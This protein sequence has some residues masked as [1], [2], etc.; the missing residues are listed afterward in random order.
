MT[1]KQETF[2][3]AIVDGLDQTAAYRLAYDAEESSQSTVYT[4]SAQLAA[5]TKVA[6]RIAELRAPVASAL[7]AKRIHTTETLVDYYEAIYAGAMADHQWAP[8]NKATE[9]IA[10]LTGNLEPAPATDV[11]ITKVTIVL[12]PSTAIVDVS[13]YKVVSDTEEES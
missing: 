1:P 2:A 10:K 12:P 3:Q 11:H 13:D 5:N 8:A 6:Q 7:V 9:G 4:N